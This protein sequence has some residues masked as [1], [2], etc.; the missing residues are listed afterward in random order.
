[1]YVFFLVVSPGT[2]IQYVYSSAMITVNMQRKN[3]THFCFAKFRGKKE[4]VCQHV[5]EPDIRI[6]MLCAYIYLSLFANVL[7]YFLK[8]ICMY[9]NKL[10]NIN[11]R[12]LRTDCV[13]TPNILAYCKCPCMWMCWWAAN[14]THLTLM[15]IRLKI[16]YVY[17]YK[18]LFPALELCMSKW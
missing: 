4:S 12:L 10:Y 11:S 17:I 5:Y 9:I 13:L 18:Y 7:V 14:K 2:H 6:Y 15:N 8:Y 16:I 3:S 1:M